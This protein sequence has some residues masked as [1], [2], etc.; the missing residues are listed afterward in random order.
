MD[1]RDGGSRAKFVHCGVRSADLGSAQREYVVSRV[2]SLA[3]RVAP[4]SGQP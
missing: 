3:G 4:Q 2:T 1:V